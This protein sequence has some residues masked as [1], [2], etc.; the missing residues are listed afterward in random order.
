MLSWMTCIFFYVDIGVCGC[1]F[2]CDIEHIG[3]FIVAVCL[4]RWNK[5]VII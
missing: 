4:V 5:Y 1:D 3:I 2:Q